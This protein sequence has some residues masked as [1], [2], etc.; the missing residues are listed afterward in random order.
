M[1]NEELFPNIERFIDSVVG[2]VDEEAIF[3]DN[4]IDA[5]WHFRHGGC[6]EF[7][8][9]VKYY[10]KDSTCMI[11]HDSNHCAIEYKGNIYDSY[12]LIKSK[13][14]YSKEELENVEYV[15]EDFVPA[16]EED[17]N[18][19]EDKFGRNIQPSSAKNVISEIEDTNMTGILYK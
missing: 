2:M 18:Y 11:T 19:M 13:S 6:Y 7:Y 16:T 1:N 3:E 12:G 17:I 4:Q 9:I 14:D 8:K 15:K 10:F 5:R